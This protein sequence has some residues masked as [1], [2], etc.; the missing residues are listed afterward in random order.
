MKNN[1]I[2]TT[3]IVAVWMKKFNDYARQH[4]HF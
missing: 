1:T 2:T 4:F 3:T